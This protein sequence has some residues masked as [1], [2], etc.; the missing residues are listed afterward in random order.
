MIPIRSKDIASGE[1]INQTTA[2]F[3][4]EHFGL[5]EEGATKLLSK[6]GKG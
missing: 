1:I 6:E 3:E 5:V 2:V 4:S